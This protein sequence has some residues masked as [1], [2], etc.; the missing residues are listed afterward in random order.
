MKR[1]VPVSALLLAAALSASSLVAATSITGPEQFHYSWRLRGA[2]AWIAG[3]RF[4]TSGFGELK[5]SVTP[6]GMASQLL[7]T[8]AQ[9]EKG[10][11][12][13]RSEIDLD[14]ERTLTSYHGYQWGEKSRKENTFFDYVK[15]LARI[16]KETP[17]EV[18]NKVRQ[19]PS[20]TIRDVLTGIHYL[21]ENSET[22]KA[23]VLS[24]IY[25]DGKIYPVLFKPDGAETLEVQGKKLATRAFLI[26]AAPSEE[27]KWPGG[28][29]VWISTDARKIPVRIEIRQGFASLRLDLQSIE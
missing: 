21:R 24:E 6:E 16:R 9:G 12:I 20:S 4:P 8:P 27:K 23:P 15:R 13:Y 11:Y 29:K 26:T 5:N 18:E 7:I 28:V 10:F 25:S 3:F 2:L 17:D 14:G 19:I 1:L 22:I